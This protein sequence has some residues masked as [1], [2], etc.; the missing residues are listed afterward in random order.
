[1]EASNTTAQHRTPRQCNAVAAITAASS[2]LN[3]CITSAVQVFTK[4]DG[5]GLV[6]SA[7]EVGKVAPR[8]N[9]SDATSETAAAAVFGELEMA[10]A[11]LLKLTEMVGWLMA[12]L[13]ALVAGPSK[14]SQLPHTSK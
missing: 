8:A 3:D 10:Q 12:G 9:T 13:D 7:L 5:Q 4:K 6:E 14:S 2:V 1:V 11:V